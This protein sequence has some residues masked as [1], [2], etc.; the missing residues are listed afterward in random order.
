MTVYVKTREVSP[1]ITAMTFTGR[2]TLGDQLTD[3]ESAIR[4]HIVEGLRK[5]V[6]DFSGLNYIDSAG[7]GVVVVCIGLMKRAGGRLAVAGAAGQVKQLLEMTGLDPLLETYPN[8]S[9][10]QTA[11]SG[12]APP[13]AA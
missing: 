6:L 12:P 10:A 4:E 5:L 1:D 8:L 2:L 13:P 7:I 9:S 11:L 3:V